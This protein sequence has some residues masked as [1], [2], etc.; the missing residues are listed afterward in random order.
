MRECHRLGSYLISQLF[1]RIIEK[2]KSSEGHYSEHV[3]AVACIAV[4]A[5]GCVVCFVYMHRMRPK[6]LRVF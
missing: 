4:D 2:T 3:I 6:S 1:D 5:H